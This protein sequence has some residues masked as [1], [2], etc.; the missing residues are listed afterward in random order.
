MP[1]H[2]TKAG[3]TVKDVDAE[4]RTI[5]AHYSV[6]GVVDDDGDVVHPGA[7]EKS[8]QKNG[9]QG[10]DRIWK[11]RDHDWTQRINKPKKITEDSDGLVMETKMPDTRLGNDVLEMYREVGDS[12]EHSVGMQL[13]EDGVEERKS[14]TGLDIFKARL[15]EGSVVPWGANHHAR[16]QGMKSDGELAQSS[17]VQRHI[18]GL[19]DL[20]SSDLTEKRKEILH[21]QLH[22]FEQEWKALQGVA[23]EKEKAE[24]SADDSVNEQAHEAVSRLTKRLSADRTIQTLTNRIQNLEL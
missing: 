4:S 18:D 11:M 20:L 15:L 14:N 13:P 21:L 24:K 8:I 3:G 16:L 6:F 5:V 9:P 23:R 17:V 22:V 19:K 12:M 7:F 2:L 1:R 10:Q